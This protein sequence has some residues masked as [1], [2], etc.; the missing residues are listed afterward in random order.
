MQRISWQDAPERC[1]VIG[2]YRESIA[3]VVPGETFIVETLDAFGN[4]VTGSDTPPSKVLS[5][6][7]VNP[8][9]GPIFV[10]G[11][12][13][14]IPWRSRSKRSNRLASLGLA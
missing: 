8:V 7:Y 11:R 2:P 5:M 14:A 6:P 10:E 12:R 13:K 9:T 3:R 4:R 1:Y